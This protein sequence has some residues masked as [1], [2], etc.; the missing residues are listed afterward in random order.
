MTRHSPLERAR[1][2][3]RRFGFDALVG[4]LL[5]RAR[6]PD[7]AAAI[8]F[9]TPPGLAYPGAEVLALDDAARPQLQVGM[10]GLTGPS[11]VLPRLY[12]E[13]V[14][15][16]LRQRSR[17]LHDFLD[18]LGQRMVAAFA[19]AGFKYRLHRAAD[20]A[21]LTEPAAP[22]AV[23]QALLAFTGHA[24]RPPASGAAV[25]DMALLHYAGLFAMRPRSADRLQALVS[26]WLGRPVTVE[27]FAGT[28]L[29]LPPDQRTALPLGALGGAWN[30]LGVD[31]TAGVRAY[32]VQGRIVLRLGPLDRA[33]FESL[34]P[35]RTGLRRLVA[36]VRAYLGLEIG[37]AVRPVLA[38]AAVPPLCLA[39]AA[40]PGPRLGWNAWLG[41]GEGRHDATEALFEAEVVERRAAMA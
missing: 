2:A 28:W 25:E 20:L 11:G 29:T 32:D 12:T 3:P 36:L 4:L 15:A 21:V 16:A 9:R 33:A 5:R 38:A 17:A 27:Q 8:S 14:A 24:D 41:G 26:D 1:R 31:A 13:S 37:F 30:R 39:A 10:I 6:Q 19:R 34:L 23:G 35:D 18:L 40:D 22:D 7:P